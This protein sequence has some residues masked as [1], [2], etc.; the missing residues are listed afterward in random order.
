MM[1][2]APLDDKIDQ[3]AHIGLPVMDPDTAPLGDISACAFR[4]HQLFF[5]M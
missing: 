3:H 2:Y 4:C 1:G 5:Y